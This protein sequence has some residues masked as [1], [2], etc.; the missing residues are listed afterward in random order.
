MKHFKLLSFLTLSVSLLL[1]SCLSNDDNH[2]GSSIATGNTKISFE[3]ANDDLD[4]RIIHEDSL[5]GYQPTGDDTRLRLVILEN[6]TDT[7]EL[8]LNEPY[9]LFLKNREIRKG[10]SVSF[11]LHPDS[12]VQYPYILKI[13]DSTYQFDLEQ[14]ELKSYFSIKQEF[15]VEFPKIYFDRENMA[16][17]E[18]FELHGVAAEEVTPIGEA[19]VDFKIVNSLLYK[20]IE[21]PRIGSAIN[22]G[23]VM[24]FQFSHELSD[25]ILDENVKIEY[26]CN[27]IECEIHPEVIEFNVSDQNQNVIALDTVKITVK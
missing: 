18:F 17:D 13:D 1:T 3:S 21:F 26:Q 4:V 12:I 16:G 5:V 11:F 6:G 14:L 2:A 23:D 19:F 22:Q 7:L 27:G 9:K 15:F 8:Q 25:L 20:E 24:V 10:I